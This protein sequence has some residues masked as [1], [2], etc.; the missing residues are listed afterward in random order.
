MSQTSPLDLLNYGV[1]AFN[2]ST[3][4]EYDFN[5]N[6]STYFE[7]AQYNIKPTYKVNPDDENIFF[8][9]L[10]ISVSPKQKKQIPY[11]IKLRLGAV[12]HINDN[13]QFPKE[14]REMLM[15]INGAAIL[16]GIAREYI[17]LAT[18]HSKG[19]SLMLPSVSFAPKMKRPRKK[20]EAS[21]KN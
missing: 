4:D 15:F 18:C 2:I 3:D 5:A 8:V 17:F 13:I 6:D 7:Y 9:D 16:Y 10:Q 1:H 20:Q 12:F 19:G 11:S 14:K 21:T